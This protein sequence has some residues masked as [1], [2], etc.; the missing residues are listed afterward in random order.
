MGCDEAEID[1]RVREAA[2]NMG[3]REELLERSPFDLSG[4]Q[5][6]RVALAGVIAMDPEILILDAPAAGLDT[7]G[8]E[9]VLGKIIDYHKRYGKT[10]L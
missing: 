8:R 9:K 7:I 2:E 4:G 3:I 1:R 10:K 5:K 6:R